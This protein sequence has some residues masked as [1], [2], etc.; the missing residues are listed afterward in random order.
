MSRRVS[1]KSIAQ[2]LGVSHMT[3]S[4]ALSNH[5]NV[6]AETRDRILTHA[7]NVGYVK[8]AAAKAMRGDKTPIVGLLLPNLVNEFYARYADSC[9]R[10]CEESGLQ[11]LIHL[12]N[13]N[14]AKEEE[15][16]R[17]LQEVQARAIVMVPAPGDGEG[18]EKLL[19]N[20]RVVQFIRKR[21][22]AGDYVT[23]KVA[24]RGAIIEAVTHLARLGHERVGYI[25]GEP[26]LSSGK[27]RLQA[28]RAGMRKNG[29]KARSDLIITDSPSFNMGH[30]AAKKLVK[31]SAVSAIVCGGFEISNGALQCCLENRVAVNE[32]LAFI[33][34]GD[35]S[36][37]RW[38]A[39]GIS[40][41]K[42]PVGPLADKTIA[43]LK[44]DVM[45]KDH[46]LEARF[47][48]R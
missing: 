42:V 23:L 26:R 30:Q 6:R 45:K 28:F 41:I 18:D 40:T 4:R 24:D 38:L 36:Y 31:S 10:R 43:L 48:P 21:E 16:I 20:I 27:D 34:Y 29:L 9:A 15:A 11:L 5:P 22:M 33:G 39:G 25:G 17:K 44:N 2:D 8:S 14:R 12:T 46:S 3:V 13:D 19:G 7:R 37:Y 1:I 35:P 47:I 32:E